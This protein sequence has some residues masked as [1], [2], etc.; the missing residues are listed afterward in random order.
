MIYITPI[1]LL[2]LSFPVFPQSFL[3]DAVTVR[4]VR[5]LC[6]SSL[7]HSITDCLILWGV[8]LTYSRNF[9]HLTLPEGSLPCSQQPDTC[10]YS[11]P[12]YSSFII[13]LSSPSSGL[14][15]SGFSTKILYVFL[16][17]PKHF[18][19]QPTSSFISPL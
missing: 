15:L 4:Y 1:F 14:F 9:P 5:V 10:S 6:T 18:P 2:L 16:Y 3:A 12:D 13:I 17:S 11:E 8:V 19:R 7:A